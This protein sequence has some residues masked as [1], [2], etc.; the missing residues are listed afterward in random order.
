MIGGDTS[1]AVQPWKVVPPATGS[2]CQANERVRASG[3]LR[4]DRYRRS[5]SQN[6]RQ[7][8]DRERSAFTRIAAAFTSTAA[9]DCPGCR[10]SGAAC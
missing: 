4:P 6:P 3:I 5:S 9:F 10:E 1:N 8:M 7:D 2:R